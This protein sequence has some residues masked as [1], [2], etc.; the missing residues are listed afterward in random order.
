MAKKKPKFY[1]TITGLRKIDLSKLDA[2]E[3]A[4]LREVVEFYKTKPDWNEYANRLNLLRQKYQIEINSSA[5]DIGYDLEARI[6]IA[7]GKVAMPNYQD[8][9]NDFIM[10]KFWS[11]DNFCRETNIT[12][13]MLA[14]V[15]A[16]KSTLGDIKLIARKLGCVLVLTHD[17][18]T[19]TDMSP[20]KAIE[21]LRRL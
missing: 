4:F 21:R 8:Q 10:E 17:S 5:A 6:G 16:G 12:T 13:K 1:E 7:E 14:Q 11:R 9:I 20:Q 19:R 15:F 3:L 18:G 2:K